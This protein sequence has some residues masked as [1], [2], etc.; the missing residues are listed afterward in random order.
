[1]AI[2]ILTPIGT[3][4]GIAEQ[5]YI[6]IKEYNISKTGA[7]N[8]Q[9]EIFLSQEDY[10]NGSTP[11]RNRIIGDSVVLDLGHDELVTTTETILATP[12][13]TETPPVNENG[14]TIMPDPI[15]TPVEETIT[16]TKVV[17][18][19]DL[20]SLE[21]NNIFTFGYSKLKEKLVTLFNEDDIID[22]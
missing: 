21:E 8:L 20:A 3:D 11:V 13:V 6:R 15:P 12:Q 22:C 18:I 2:K 9:L 1:M 4:Y 17:R 7:V 16:T 19:I 5:A 10:N 14:E